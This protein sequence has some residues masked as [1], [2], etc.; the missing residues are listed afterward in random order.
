LVVFF[1]FVLEGGEKARFAFVFKPVTFAFDIDDGGAMQETV[2]SSAGHDRVA[3]KDVGPLGRGLVGSDDGGGVFLVAA[4]DDLEEHGG[5]G[6]IEVEITDF[7]DDQ[8]LWLGKNLHGRGQPVLFEGRAETTR[9]F[10]GGKGEE[11][12]SEFRGK[13]AEGDSEM[14]FADAERTQEQNIAAFRKETSNG[15]LLDGGLTEGWKEKSKSS[16]YLR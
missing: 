4:A 9:H 15:Q 12:V 8:E 13:D 2:E 16:S 5:A 10:R 14:G 6:L 1:G 3:A 7:V 11:A